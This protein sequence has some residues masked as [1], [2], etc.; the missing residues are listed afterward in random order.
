MRESIG[1]SGHRPNKLGGYDYLAFNL[2]QSIFLEWLDKNPTKL[3]RTGM[4]LGWDQA[5]AQACI[6]A[7]VPFTAVIP[8]IGQENA[9]PEK[10]QVYYRWLIERAESQLVVSSGG[11]AAW[12]MQVRNE[13]IVDNVS[14]LI[15]MHDGSTGGTNNCIKYAKK[16][17][18]TEEQIINLYD[19]WNQHCNDID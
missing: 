1:V 5:V 19:V 8:F 4:A 6:T 12:K 3:V 17:G 11:Y 13:W 9:W 14:K 15:V 16:K 2:L 7:N 10:S 18:F